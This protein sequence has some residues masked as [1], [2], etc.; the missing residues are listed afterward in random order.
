MTFPRSRTLIGAMVLALAA[1]GGGDGG[2]GPSGGGGTGGGGTGG[3]GTG[4]TIVANPSFATHIQEIFTRNGCTAAGCHGTSP[5]AGL[6][7]RG[8]G[9]F[10]ALVGVSSVNEPSRVRVIANDAQ[11]S[12]LVIKLEGRQSVGTRMPQTG[13]ALDNIDLTNV[14]NW[15]NTGAP[16]N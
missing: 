7:L 15:I 5:Q 8:S 13:A 4:R 1:C 11:N 3:G 6:D 2:T 16:N 12:Y 9:A 10:A 14:R